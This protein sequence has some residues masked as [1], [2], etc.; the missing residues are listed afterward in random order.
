MVATDDPPWVVEVGATELVRDVDVSAGGEV[1]IVVRPH[2]GP[3]RGRPSFT[4]E[5]ER[6]RIVRRTHALGAGDAT[7]YGIA[8][9][10][11]VLVVAID[12][13]ERERTPFTVR[14][15]ESTRVSVTLP[16]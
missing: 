16:E 12:D 1:R 9:G 13:V 11:Y 14:A 3:L 10:A 2:I 8:P 6:Q 5:D 15:H 4:I 7:R